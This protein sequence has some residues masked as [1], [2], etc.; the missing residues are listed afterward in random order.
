MFDGLDDLPFSGQLSSDPFEDYITSPPIRSISN[1]LA[2]WDTQK[3]AKIDSS[4]AQ[5]ALNYLSVPCGFCHVLSTGCTLTSFPFAATSVDVERA[6]SMG[7]Q[8]ITKLRNRLSDKTARASI[9]LASWLQHPEFTARVEMKDLL[10]N[11]W[12]RGKNR[13][14]AEDGGVEEV[15]EIND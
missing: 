7:G 2:F 13:L 11:R 5:M 14:D 3:K 1:P 9:V 6:F 12:K 15:I 4:L 8:V 10:E